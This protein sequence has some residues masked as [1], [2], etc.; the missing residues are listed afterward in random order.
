VKRNKTKLSKLHLSIRAKLKLK[1][2]G[3]KSEQKI[4]YYRADELH[5]KKKII[6]EIN[7]DYVHANPKIYKSGDRILLR[8]N[9]YTAEEKWIKDAK[10]LDDL[11]AMGYRVIVVWESDDLAV[12]RKLVVKYMNE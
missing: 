8:G 3:F 5:P 4:G 1:D 10:K 7:G 2:F 12:I 9:T 6:I 11:K